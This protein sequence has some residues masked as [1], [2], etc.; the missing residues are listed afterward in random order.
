MQGG[1]GSVDRRYSLEGE[2]VA[3]EVG[4]E[5]DSIDTLYLT[6]E[7][8][9]ATEAIEFIAGHLRS[10]DEYIQV[11][12]TFHSTIITY[13][14]PLSPL[15]HSLHLSITFFISLRSIPASCS[16]SI[17]FQIREDWKYVAMVIDRLQLYL[18]FLVTTFGTLAILLD[19]PH[20]FE[21]VDQDKVI[22]MNSKASSWK[23]MKWHWNTIGIGKRNL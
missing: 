8:Y 11:R 16:F 12:S 5:D 1:N 17:S 10:E 22:Q 14:T 2:G 7:A 23:G 4:E 18:F 15:S 13:L 6:P 9:R 3:K 19:A 21:F 20:I